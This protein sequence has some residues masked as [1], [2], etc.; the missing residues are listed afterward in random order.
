MDR[1]HCLYDSRV[2]G[3][4]V[5]HPAAKCGLE[6]IHRLMDK[7]GGYAMVGRGLQCLQLLYNFSPS[8][9][10]S[11]PYAVLKYLPR[12]LHAPADSKPA[13]PRLHSGAN[14]FVKGFGYIAMQRRSACPAGIFITMPQ[15]RSGVPWQLLFDTADSKSEEVYLMD[16]DR[17]TLEAHSLAVLR[18][19]DKDASGGL[20]AD[21]GADPDAKTR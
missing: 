13:P 15:L 17:Y 3:G 16:G 1:D 21:A 7:S 18:L 5:G 19:G 12:P 9:I 8:F 2:K 4:F 10:P 6:V 20:S 14:Q 11:N